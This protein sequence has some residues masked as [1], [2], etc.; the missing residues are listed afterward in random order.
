MAWLCHSLDVLL[1]A[2][3]SLCNFPPPDAKIVLPPSLRLTKA[4]IFSMLYKIVIG[5]LH[6]LGR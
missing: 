1:V 5:M 4:D 3:I 2:Y 6:E